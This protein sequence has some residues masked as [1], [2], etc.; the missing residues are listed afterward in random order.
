MK[1]F[2]RLDEDFIKLLEDM[3]PLTDA[4]LRATDWDRA[5]LAGQ[6]DVVQKLRHEY[7]KQQKQFSK[8]QIE[9]RA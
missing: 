3:Y 4:D 7:G 9:R 1:E 6:R 8:S 2:P 5:F